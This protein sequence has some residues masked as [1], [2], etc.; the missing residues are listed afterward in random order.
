LVF[1][2]YGQSDGLVGFL[3]PDGRVSGLSAIYSVNASGDVLFLAQGN[4][5]TI[6]IIL[7]APNFTSGTT[8]TSTVTFGTDAPFDTSCGL[9][10]ISPIAQDPVPT[11]IPTGNL[12]AQLLNR[13]TQAAPQEGWSCEGTLLGFYGSGQGRIG[14]DP[15]F[16]VMEY[17]VNSDTV[18]IRINGLSA[19][20]SNILF[21]GPDNFSTLLFDGSLTLGIECTRFGLSLASASRSASEQN[22]VISQWKQLPHDIRLKADRMPAR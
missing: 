10:S 16:N 19:E 22:S 12:E 4:T 21:S 15:N 20:M 3:A 14:R 2:L 9:I 13:G 18:D 8:F 5:G 11:P 6:P 17:T 7:Q 1:G